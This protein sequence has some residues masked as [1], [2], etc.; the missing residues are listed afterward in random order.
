MGSA[1]IESIAETVAA[2]SAEMHHD[3]DRW[4][5]AYDA[6]A[7]EI[8]GFPAFY[9]AAMVVGIALE[10]LADRLSVKWGE[11]YDWLAAT[12]GAAGATLNFITRK[13]RLPS[14][15]EAYMLARESMDSA[16]D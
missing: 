3:Q 11:G 14:K 6:A 8:G 2:V 15:V 7:G 12:S 16:R 5:K 9:T 10:N 1:S 4:R 13:K